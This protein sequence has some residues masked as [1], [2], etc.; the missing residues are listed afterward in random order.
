MPNLIASPSDFIY[1]RPRDPSTTSLIPEYLEDSAMESSRR[2]KATGTRSLPVTAA[3]W[4]AVRSQLLPLS[5]GECSCSTLDPELR[6]VKTE[7]NQQ[8]PQPIL[9]PQSNTTPYQ[10]QPNIRAPSS[11]FLPTYPDSPTLA[12]FR[13]EPSISEQSADPPPVVNPLD[14]RTASLASGRTVS[15]PS[16]STERTS[17]I[18][19]LIRSIHNVCLQATQV[20]IDTH[21]ANRRARAASEA[22]SIVCHG[23]SSGSLSSASTTDG[24]N[25][26]NGNVNNG[27]DTAD[28]ICPSIP[29]ATSSLLFNTSGICSML[30]NGSQRD[31][32]HVLN[33]ERMAIESMGRL[34]RWAETVALGDWRGADEEA[35]WQVSEAGLNLCNW[36]GVTDA[37]IAMTSLDG[38]VQGR[39][40]GL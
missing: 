13:H 11:S 8:S 9:Y 22:W 39:Y 6:H 33:V 17:S 37:I 26:G 31:R 38:E 36:L 23:N 2:T 12:V 30:W 1:R 27:R 5:S 29:P 34:M 3:D 35:L 20:Y 19:S 18:C 14:S 16:N 40:P 32:L 24:I 7:D 28:G 25:N 15:I 21:I 4:E 10:Q